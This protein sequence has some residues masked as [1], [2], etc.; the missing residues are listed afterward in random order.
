MK[1]FLFLQIF[2]FVGLVTSFAQ[3][4]WQNVDSLY[5]P[6][7][8]SVHIFRT[9]DQL[10]GKPN[11]A[12]YLVADLRDK[13]LDFTVDT[14]YK[15]RLNPS[16]FYTKNNNPILVVNT[17]FFSFATDQNLNVVIRD[18]KLVSYNIHT[19]P[20]KGK[21]TLTYRHPFGSAIGIS[22]KRKADVAWLYTDSIIS[23]PKASRW[24]IPPVK[25]SIE[26]PGWLYL[27]YKTSIPQH[28]GFEKWKMQTAVGGGPVLLQEGK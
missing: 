27:S 6:L 15:R 19:I 17:T 3:L 20:G 1:R 18:G 4:N 13:K 21:D 5:Q 11:N 7:P 16:Q 12:Y 28:M 22:R 14:T 23:V 8:P 25:D 26:R 10:D 9:T 24:V 2:L